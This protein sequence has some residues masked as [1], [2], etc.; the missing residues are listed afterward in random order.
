M[1]ELKELSGSE[2]L[3]IIFQNIDKWKERMEQELE[4][5]AHANEV[6]NEAIPL[7]EVEDVEIN[8]RLEEIHPGIASILERNEELFMQEVE[9]EL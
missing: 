7:E 5:K 4:I 1:P 8:R 9:E 2:S 3:R 6:K